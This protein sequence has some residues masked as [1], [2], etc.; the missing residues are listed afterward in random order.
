MT[1]VVFLLIAIPLAVFALAPIRHANMA[2]SWKNDKLDFIL[3]KH[4]VL[5]LKSFWVER[6]D[7]RFSISAVLD[8]WINSINFII[9]FITICL[10]TI[11]IGSSISELSNISDLSNTIGYK[12]EKLFIYSLFVNFSLTFLHIL[13]ILFQFR[14][15]WVPTSRLVRKRAVAEA[16]AAGSELAHLE[17]NKEGPMKDSLL[18]QQPLSDEEYDRY[19]ADPAFQ[20]AVAQMVNDRLKNAADVDP[21]DQ[22]PTDEEVLVEFL[23]SKRLYQRGN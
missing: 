1:A 23:A 15:N 8:E 19:L 2:S 20:K 21:Y 14:W 10:F 6:S 18:V 16:A 7:R 17:V 4:R 12:F 9:A 13:W 11:Y 3:S 5:S 22:G